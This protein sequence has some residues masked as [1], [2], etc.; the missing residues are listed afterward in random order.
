MS[1]PLKRII[2]RIILQNAVRFEEESYRFYKHALQRSIMSESFNLIKFLLSQELEHR[3]KLLDV[4]KGRSLD[5]L[6]TGGGKD[7]IATGPE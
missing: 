1:G 4:L 7:E 5:D 6:G 2:I 3:M